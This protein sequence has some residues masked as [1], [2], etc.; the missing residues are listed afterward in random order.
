MQC[1]STQAYH[2]VSFVEEVWTWFAIGT[3]AISARSIVRLRTVHWSKLQ[4]DDYLA[5]AVWLC[6]LCDS[7]TITLIYYYGSNVDFTSEEISKMSQ[8]QI[9]RIRLGSKMQLLAW[10]TYTAL[11]W[12]LKSMMLCFFH[13]LMFGQNQHRLIKVLAVACALSYA[14]VFV[15]I[16][17]GCHPYSRNWKVRPLP[18]DKCTRKL[19][20]FYVT[21]VLNVVTDAAI[22]TIPLPLLWQLKVPLKRKIAL[23]LLLG[24][25]IFVIT[26]ALLRLS[27]TLTS[28]NALNINI[29]GTRETIAGI[30]AVNA[31]I[32]K[33]IFYASFWRRGFDPSRTPTPRLPNERSS[34]EKKI[35]SASKR[36]NRGLGL[37]S[38]LQSM[39]GDDEKSKST[40]AA[41]A[42]QGS[43]S[44]SAI[45]ASTDVERG[46]EIA[47]LSAEM[48]AEMW[49]TSPQPLL[50]EPALIW[51]PGSRQASRDEALPPIVEVQ[52]NCSGV[53]GGK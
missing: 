50:P 40:A 53:A 22:L 10:Y 42:R 30:L 7:V 51:P 29:W 49:R 17:C 13:R 9:D 44:D 25:G 43:A 35:G 26:A 52:T 47:S 6:F 34:R 4:G 46:W 12:L 28:L 31:P 21:T 33:P 1:P 14:A 16:S 15:T 48:A 5:L 38:I 20:N 18:P 39:A 37:L 2:D 32:L 24:S 41:V 27:F 45:A 23:T 8:C 3:V 11:I 19:Q 36:D